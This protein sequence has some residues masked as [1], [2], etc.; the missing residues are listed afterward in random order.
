[1]AM[2]R[3]DVELTAITAAKVAMECWEAQRKRANERIYGF[4]LIAA[5]LDISL[6]KLRRL[7]QTKRL[8]LDRDPRGYSIARWELDRWMETNRRPVVPTDD[9]DE[10]DEGSE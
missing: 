5:E 9:E 2:T 7:V 4:K 3:E 10:S 6:D 8:P 1:M